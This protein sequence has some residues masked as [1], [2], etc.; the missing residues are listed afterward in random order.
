MKGV[1]KMADIIEELE[2]DT[3][4]DKYITFKSNNEYFALEI[5]IVQ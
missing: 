1:E 2:E 3:Q 5:R 4:K